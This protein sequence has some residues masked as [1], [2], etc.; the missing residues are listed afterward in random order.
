[1]TSRAEQALSLFNTGSNCGQATAAPFAAEYGVAP[2]WVAR[3]M[4]GF[5]AGMGG[6]RETCGAVSA[7]VFIAGLHAGMGVAADHA[8]KRDLYR[9]V[10]R[11]CGEFERTHGTTCCRELLAQAAV[12]TSQDPQE[13]D[14]NYY[15][16]RPCARFVLTAAQIL[17]REL[18]SP[19]R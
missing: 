16:K 10:K 4:A 8:K 5:G 2:E 1:M 7:M 13:R 17:E 11:L 19:A 18:Q 9:L 15:A 6:R 14:A 12:V 3:A